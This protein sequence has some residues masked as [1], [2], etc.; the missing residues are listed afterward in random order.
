MTVML[1]KPKKTKPSKLRLFFRWT[2]R[3]T[4]L[5]IILALLAIGYTFRADL[6]K[7]FVRFPKEAKAWAAIKADR[8][9]VTLDDGWMDYRGP[10]H[11][12]SYIS[13]DSMVS[14]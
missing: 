14:A 4:A 1:P 2:F 8:Q 12:H 10:I 5:L 7:L 3:I 13:H 11:N 6:Y 9:E